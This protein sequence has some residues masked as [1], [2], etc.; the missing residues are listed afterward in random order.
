MATSPIGDFSRRGGRH[1]SGFTLIELLVVLVVIGLIA[2]LAVPRLDR[3]APN[4]NLRNTARELQAEFRQAR[5]EAIRDNR[6]SWLLFD[7]ALGGWR[8]DGQSEFTAV[9]ESVRLTLVTAQREQIDD[10]RGRVRFFPDGTS[11]GGS[12]TLARGDLSYDV[13]VDWFDGR[14]SVDETKAE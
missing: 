9:T 7:V 6:E 3:V 5:S 4:F 12:V 10:A 11:T 13:A 14:V 2:A 1:S 8:R